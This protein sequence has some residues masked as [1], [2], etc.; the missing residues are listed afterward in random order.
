MQFRDVVFGSELKIDVDGDILG[1]DLVALLQRRS[2]FA[3]MRIY[4]K[5]SAPSAIR[6]GK[7][8]LS[9]DPIRWS[10][11]CSAPYPIIAPAPGFDLSHAVVPSFLL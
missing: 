7:P 2:N 6:Q 11:N 4:L 5:L 8:V 3:C 10:I 9:I 1:V